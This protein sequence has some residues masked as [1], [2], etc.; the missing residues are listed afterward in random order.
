MSSIPVPNLEP[1]AE[2]TAEVGAAI[3]VG[4]GPH[5]RRRV[6]PILGGRIS[7]PRLN[8]RVLPGANDYQ[9]VR[10]DGVLELVARYVIETDDKALIYVENAGLRDGPA[11][12]IARQLAGE[13][14]DPA[15]I[16]FRTVPRFETAAPRY[17]WLT[18]R[19]F[20]GS[21]ARFPDRVA[22]RFFAVT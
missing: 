4:H 14:V 22:L 10:G 19:I 5:G 9:L 11:D 17:D 2:L 18:R 12:L 13:P 8:G 21:G 1:V 20:V 3:D 7:G 15:R 6:I 16:Y